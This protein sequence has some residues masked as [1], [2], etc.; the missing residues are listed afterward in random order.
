MAE[1]IYTLLDNRSVLTPV[2]GKDYNHSL[3]A[4]L[5]PTSEQF[6]DDTKLVAWADENGYTAKLIQ[7][8]LQKGIIEVRAA[9][10]ACK[11][12]ETWS[13]ELGEKNLASMEWSTVTRPQTSMSDEEKAM[14]I[15][16]KL[17]PE[18]IAEMLAKLGK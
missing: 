16:G 7:K 11:K 13:E 8:G 17:T 2:N 12:T 9:F 5:F 10:K 3:P 15:L 1:S 6:G 4:S 14:S 18:Q